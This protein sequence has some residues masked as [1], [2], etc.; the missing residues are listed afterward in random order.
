MKEKW[1]MQNILFNIP[2]LEAARIGLEM[3]VKER[4]RLVQLADNNHK[5]EAL[6]LT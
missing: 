6:K 5:E 2:E 1:V 4:E 3:V